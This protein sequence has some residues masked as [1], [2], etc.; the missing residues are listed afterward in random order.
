MTMTKINLVLGR[1]MRTEETAIKSAMSAD[2]SVECA[3]RGQF[4][5][6]ISASGTI[7]IIA[8]GTLDVSMIKSLASATGPSTTSI[9]NVSTILMITA[10]LL[11]VVIAMPAVPTDL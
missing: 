4:S 6:H 8:T 1:E 7:T 2:A 11:P 5:T 10:K 9:L 3:P